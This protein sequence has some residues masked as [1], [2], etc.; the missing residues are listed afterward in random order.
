MHLHFGFHSMLNWDYS[1]FLMVHFSS[2][3]CYPSGTQTRMHLFEP[4]ISWCDDWESKELSTTSTKP[5][6][7]L[8]K[9]S[10]VFKI[11]HYMLHPADIIRVSVHLQ[12][13]SKGATAKLEGFDQ[14]EIIVSFL[15]SGWK[16][17]RATA[18][19]SDHGAF[20]RLWKLWTSHVQSLLGH[21]G[22]SR[23]IPAGLP[24]VRSTHAH[25]SDFQGCPNSPSHSMPTGKPNSHFELCCPH[26]L[27]RAV[28]VKQCGRAVGI[29]WHCWGWSPEPSF[30]QTPQSCTGIC[31]QRCQHSSIPSTTSTT[32]V[33]GEGVRGTG[34]EA[35][36]PHTSGSPHGFVFQHLCYL[37]SAPV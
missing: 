33:G 35:Q 17:T 2:F 19:E 24:C 32:G 18:V 23:I 36:K 7:S 21:G 37:W 31:Y 6:W 8:F 4:I 15:Q 26:C 14:Q 3:C 34:L 27:H 20:K 16:K 5:F 25:P 30:L 22:K 13:R 29:G 1:G 10:P 9:K 12:F 11:T 28:A